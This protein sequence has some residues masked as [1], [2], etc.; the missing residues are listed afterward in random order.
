M[1]INLKA[2]NI[3]PPA[4]FLLEEVSATWRV[5]ADPH[6][7][8]A[9]APGMVQIVV[10]PNL[11][12]QRR[13]VAVADLNMIVAGVCAELMRNV[14]GISPID[15][16]GLRFA[17]GREGSLLKYTMPGHKEFK[18]VQLQAMRL[19]DDIVTSAMLSTEMSRLN[20]GQLEEL[21]ACLASIVPAT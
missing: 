7:K 14:S 2:L 8:E 19:D 10:R 4:G 12:V 18:I 3:T 21:L 6:V 5:A 20:A 16:T 17:D 1:D 13:K 11:I 9:R 15:T